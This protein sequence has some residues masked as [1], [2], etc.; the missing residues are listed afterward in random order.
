MIIDSK[1]S[2]IFVAIAKTGC[3]SI[4]RRFGLHNDPKPD[5]Y[6]MHLSEILKQNPETKDYF[7]FAFVR[8]P[9][10]RLISAYF[11]FKNNPQH[12]DWA[13]PIYKY[14]SFGQFVK[15][16]YNKKFPEDDWI[17]LHR[18]FDYLQVGGKVNLD[19]IGRVETLQQDMKNVE[20]LLGINHSPLNKERSSR[21]DH[22]ASYYTADIKRMV[23]EIYEEDFIEFGYER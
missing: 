16:I 14:K 13:S 12:K 8:N 5:I 7:K 18:Q 6:H 23:Y 10:D 22:F 2:F 15:D 11:D 21:H 4:Q 17:H 19:Y 1:R 9:Y 3:T 20:S